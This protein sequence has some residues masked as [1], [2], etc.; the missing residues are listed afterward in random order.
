MTSDD[1]DIDL[2]MPPMATA[3]PFPATSVDIPLAT[4]LTKGASLPNI[5][6]CNNNP[7]LRQDQIDQLKEQGFPQGL[8]AELG[9]TR[10]VYPLRFWVAD[11]SGTLLFLFLLSLL[12]M[13]RYRCNPSVFYFVTVCLA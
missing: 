11:N 7:V 6:S 9:R 1:K 5:V 4:T 3:V 2:S 13:Y 8:A 10:A 12:M